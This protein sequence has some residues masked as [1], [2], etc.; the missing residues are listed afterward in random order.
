MSERDERLEELR[1]ERSSEAPDDASLAFEM[2]LFDDGAEAE[3]R[4]RVR[5][6]LVPEVLRR[7][8]D[9]AAPEPIRSRRPSARLLPYAAAAVLVLG[10]TGTAA[11]ATWGLPGLGWI[12]DLVAGRPA[13]APVIE[14]PSPAPRPE[15]SLPAEAPPQPEKGD[16]APAPPEP[17]AAEPA[18]AAEA[19]PPRSSRSTPRRGAPSRKRASGL[20]NPAP[21]PRGEPARARSGRPIGTA[22]PPREREPDPVPEPS[23]ASASELFETANLARDRGDVD[24]ALRSYR[25]LRSTHPRTSEAVFSFV[26][27]GRIELA[28]GRARSALQAFRAYLRKA[29]TGVLAEAAWVGVA[30]AARKAQ[31]SNAEREAWQA[32]LRR[33]PKSIHGA[34]AR[35]RLGAL[36]SP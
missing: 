36:G 22:R 26:S 35:Q 16:E 28:R 25:E 17:P 3:A 6:G 13:P 31:D 24:Q 27:E 30:E 15:P 34:R 11:A 23:M 7:L 20:P 1:A 18:A 8:D 19:P 5:V 4:G 10:L 33:F 32:V 12:R 2:G 21:V 29:P 14:P 9:A